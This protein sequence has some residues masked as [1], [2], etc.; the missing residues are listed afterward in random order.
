M[1]DVAN[2]SE[3]FLEKVK[4]ADVEDVLILDEAGGSPAEQWR[5]QFTMKKILQSNRK[6]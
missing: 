6:K 1:S 2:D 3:E 4:E 5:F